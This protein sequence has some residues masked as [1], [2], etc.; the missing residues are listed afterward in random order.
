MGEALAGFGE[1]RWV[2][3]VRGGWIGEKSRGEIGVSTIWRELEDSPG[4]E[5]I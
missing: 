3:R 4:F 5:R 1:M 2:S